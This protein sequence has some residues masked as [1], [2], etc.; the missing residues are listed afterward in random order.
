MY[1]QITT[2]CNMNCSHCCYS[3]SMRGKHGDLGVILRGIEF[4]YTYD[5]SH[6]VI[7]GGE[8][9]LHPDF[10]IILKKCLV[11]FDS[12]WMATNGS[13]TAVMHRLAR[14]INGCDY[15]TFKCEC[16]ASEKD[17]GYWDC[18]CNHDIISQEDKLTVAVSND[19]FHDPIN[20]TIMETWRKRSKTTYNGYELRNVTEQNDGIAGQGRAKKMGYGGKRCVCSDYILKPDGTIRMCGCTRSPV[21]GDVWGGVEI[22]WEKEM[23]GSDGYAGT[24][25]YKDL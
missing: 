15:E 1:L 16:E 8:P 3:C 5:D 2:K 25:C 19:Y 22:E 17:S 7:G 21:V 24:R 12:V 4:A 20:E 6:I 23:N 9:T 10:F 11:L 13:Q 14:I 18:N